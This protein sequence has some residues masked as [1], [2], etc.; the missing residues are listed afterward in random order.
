[1]RLIDLDALIKEIKDSA[2]EPQYYHLGEDWYVGMACAEEIVLE[3]PIIFD[4]TK[5]VSKKSGHADDDTIPDDIFTT[6]YG[7]A[8]VKKV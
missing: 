5:N 4:T 7:G 2:N 6:I 8:Y 1:M 3:Q